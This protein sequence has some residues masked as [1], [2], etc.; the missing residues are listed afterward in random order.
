M[1]DNPTRV[2][3]QSHDIDTP[4][5]PQ[6]VPPRGIVGTVVSN[7]EGLLLIPESEL[8]R[9][10]A[11][12]RELRAEEAMQAREQTCEHCDKPLPPRRGTGGKPRRFCSAK[13]RRA[14]FEPRRAV[15]DATRQTTPMVANAPPTFANVD[16]DDGR[17]DWLTDES[18]VIGEQLAT[19]IYQNA[20][21]DLVIRQERSWADEHD[22]VVII[23]KINA[24]DFYQRLGD[25]IGIPTLRG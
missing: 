17:F 15:V 4:C 5:N 18:V 3:A 16:D 14:A 23:A 19:A 8:Q 9:V 1:L 20:A 10:D 2:R 24:V 22:H 7:G 11:I 6:P 25:V 12:G 21:G 13:C